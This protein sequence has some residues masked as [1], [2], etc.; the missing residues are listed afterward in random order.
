VNVEYTLEREEMTLENVLITIPLGSTDVPKIKSCDGLCRH[1]PRTN[2]I[3]WKFDVSQYAL[4]LNIFI[5]V[6]NLRLNLIQQVISGDNSGGV[7]EFD[8]KSPSEDSFFP[9]DV[10]FSSRD[11][12][13]KMH[14]EN[15][16]N[17]M[18]GSNIKFVAQSLCVTAPYTI[19]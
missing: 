4:F 10:N 18:D 17:A 19:S 9:I 2:S 1:N 14:V 7:L 8:V 16:V 5:Y 12:Y 3:E 6:Y 15:V 11:T 13:C